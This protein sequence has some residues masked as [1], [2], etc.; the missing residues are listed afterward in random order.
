M[1]IS[2]AVAQL[3]LK[4]QEYGYDEYYVARVGEGRNNVNLVDGWHME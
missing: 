2:W 3:A 4:S 1:A